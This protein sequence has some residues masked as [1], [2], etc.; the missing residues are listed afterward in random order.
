M[1]ALREGIQ[2]LPPASTAPKVPDELRIWKIGIEK[3]KPN[4]KQPRQVFDK[5]PLDELANSI[6][7][8]GIIQPLL[9]RKLANGNFE[10]IAGERRWR[11]AQLADLKE[12]PVVLKETDDKETLE[13]ALIENI[14]RQE[15]NP[16]EEA[17]AYDYLM[18]TYHLTQQELAERVGKERAT[19]ANVLRL[20][21]LCPDVRLMVSIAEIS[22]G[23]AKVLLSVPDRE[24][25]I[26][27]A[28][29]AKKENLS[30][31]ALEQLINKSRSPKQETTPESQHDLHIRHVQEEIQKIIG[32]KVAVD[33]NDGKGKM[34]FYFYSDDEMNDMVERIRRSWR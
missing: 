10:I 5:E 14:Q 1:A 20:L 12:V 2:E 4:P 3:L 30:V 8:K 28:D 26:K 15:L 18:T 9:A 21:N 32:S 29:R 34:S 33:Y 31:R 16:I 13:L 11:A 19:V 22:L 17:E 23:H 7:E 25:Q 6:R 24:T 27:L